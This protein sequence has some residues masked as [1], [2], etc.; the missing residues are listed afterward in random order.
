M[1]RSSN[2]TRRGFLSTAAVL[3]AS[4]VVTVPAGAIEADPV[5]AAIEAH[6][7]AD[8]ACVAV[9]G[10]IPDVLADR[11]SDAWHLVMRTRA[12]TP[13]G[14]AALTMWTRE[15][16][17][18]LAQSG[19]GLLSSDFLTLAATID[20]SARGMS[21]LSPWSPPAIVNPDAEI[22]AAGAAFETLFNKYLDLRFVW[23]R[24]MR[25]AGAE[26][27][28]KYPKANDSFN[29]PKWA[30]KSQALER[31]GGRDVSERLSVISDEMLP[32]ESLIRDAATITVEGLRAKMLVAVR[33]CLPIRA[34]HNGYLTF[35]DDQSHWSL[36]NGAAA[37]TGLSETVASICERLEADATISADAD[38]VA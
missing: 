4:A 34:T 21:G 3:A 18:E 25:E 16:A 9:D 7:R 24:L 32:L 8:A 38:E 1:T 37:V 35:E 17:A 15:Q 6:R 19:S 31:N 30:F 22:I 29:S 28:A 23:A 27:E 11:C 10:N 2:T 20:D 26:M 36:F 13:G 14:L 5:F 33:D 12:T